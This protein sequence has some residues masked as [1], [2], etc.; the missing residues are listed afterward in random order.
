MWD[1]FSSLVQAVLWITAMHPREITDSPALLSRGTIPGGSALKFCNES[2]GTDLY[3]IDRIE[4][5]PKP[6]Y[7]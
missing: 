1:V 3:A 6:L 4:L 5:Y 7:M 2:R